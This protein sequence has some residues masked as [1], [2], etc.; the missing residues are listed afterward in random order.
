MTRSASSAQG[1]N[2]M[3]AFIKNDR[4]GFTLI[5]V[6]VYSAIL[7][8]FFLFGI[9]FTSRIIDY[10]DRLEKQRELAEN[11]RFLEQKLQWA[12]SSIQTLSSPPL[13]TSSTTLS[14]T[15]LGYASNPVSFNRATATGMVRIS[16]L[17]GAPVPLLNRFA[18]ATSLTFDNLNLNG[19]YAIRVRGALQNNVATS[20]IDMLVYYK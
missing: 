7:A 4:H 20:S 5:E 15:K 19:Q 12:L 2:R 1:H 10:G 8:G 6:V 11:Q 14:V 18:T 13:G 3:N 17:G 9:T 16:I